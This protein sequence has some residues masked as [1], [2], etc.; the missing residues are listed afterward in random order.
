MVRARDKARARVRARAMIIAKS[1]ARTWV[2]LCL[3]RP[4]HFC[5]RTKFTVTDHFTE[6]CF[7]RGGCHGSVGWTERRLYS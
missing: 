2:C 4:D 7:E 3:K 1:R 6:D 5:R